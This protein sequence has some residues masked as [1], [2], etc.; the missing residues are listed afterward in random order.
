MSTIP[1]YY[2]FI[3]LA[4]VFFLYGILICV[5]YIAKRLRGN[6]D[7]DLI[8]FRPSLLRGSNSLRH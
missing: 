8:R 5:A 1:G 7:D 2:I 4:A 3:V 6:E